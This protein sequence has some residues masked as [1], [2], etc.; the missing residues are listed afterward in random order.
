MVF[1]I[2]LLRA[3]VARKLYESQPNHFVATHSVLDGSSD[4]KRLIVGA[5]FAAN[6]SREVAASQ[7]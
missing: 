1:V 3:T 4:T 5:N 6:L 7:K 2:G